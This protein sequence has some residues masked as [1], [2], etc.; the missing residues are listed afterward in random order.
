MRLKQE[1]G[2]IN[3]FEK[4]FFLT[5][6]ITMVSLALSIR[7]LNSLSIIILVLLV[8]FHPERR[9]LV[10]KAFTH[11]IFLALAALF[12][13]QV[14][15]LFYTS[16]SVRGWR[17][18]TQKAGLIGIPFFFCAIPAISTKRMRELMAVFSLSL[19]LVSLYCLLY[20]CLGYNRTGDPSV[21]FYHKLVSPFQHHAIF[22]S[23]FLWYCVIYWMEQGAGLNRKKYA[24]A[25]M[26]LV[27]FFLLM[28]FLLS[29]KLVII[30]TFLYLIIFML[31]L[32]QRKKRAGMFVTS[33]VL[34]GTAALLI[35]TTHNP[36][37]ARFDDL[38]RGNAYLF[39]EKQFSPAVYFNGLQFRLL[40]WRFTGEILEQKKAWWVGVSPGDAQQE[41]NRR[42]EEMHMYLGD[43]KTDTGFR[44]FNCHNVYLQT[45]LETG[46]LGLFFLLL[47]IFFFLREAIRERKFRALIFFAAILAFGFTESLTSSQYTL[48]LLLFFPLLSLKEAS[49]R[50]PIY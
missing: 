42:Y 14:A 17:E 36:I 10:R 3:R 11:P 45:L 48:L 39:R 32:V 28:I 35:F 5:L 6:I 9:V 46:G 12:L 37:K 13:M 50:Q 4:A 16:D 25:W 38:T 41:L 44:D 20:A 29:S 8:L 2:T 23:F 31:R 47:A 7:F 27:I 22:F 15:G 43:G 18:L 49:P 21:F 40:T 30:V 34:V 33:L 26:A 24:P 1:T 19:L